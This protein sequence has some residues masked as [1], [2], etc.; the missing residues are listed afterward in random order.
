MAF[1]YK[2]N[3]LYIEECSVLKLIEQYRSPCYLYSNSILQQRWIEFKHALNDYPHQICYAVKA[4]SNLAILRLLAKQGAGFDVVSSGELA[5]VIKAGGDPTQCVF[6]GVGKSISEIR[7]ALQARIGCFNVESQEELIRIE[8][9]A[10]A[11]QIKAPIALRINP[12]IDANT[13]PY[14]TTGIKSSKFGVSEQEALALYRF[15]AQSPH[16]HVT[17]IACHLGSQLT[18][19]SPFLEALDQLLLLVDQLAAEAIHLHHIDIGGGLGIAYNQENVPT[20]EAYGQ[21]LIKKLAGRDRALR[22]IIEP[23]RALI[24]QAGILVTRVEYL[25]T[26]LDHHFAIV[27]AGMT[28]L[29]RPALYQA[30]Q[31]IG[32]VTQK[33][34]LPQ[35][36]YD[37]VGPICE[38]SDF[39]GKNRTLQIEAGDYL[40]V[41][42]CGAYGFSMS[43]QYNTRP[44]CAEVFVCGQ[45][46]TLIRQRES[47]ERCW[48]DELLE[49]GSVIDIQGKL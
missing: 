28:E 12:N 46:S 25:K 10:A 13:H 48:A 9:Q 5:R 20:P 35:K 17:G 7:A 34:H 21:A 1:Y 16:L 26:N 3:Q 49:T 31:R 42:D 24:A 43:S 40:V 47:L 30:E 15:A 41:Y 37:V 32:S 14:I 39:L 4:N 11:L 33:P 27:D 8:A 2:Q 38:S 23:G 44:R 6:S 45:Q 18:T 22:L 19:L 29:L 36:K